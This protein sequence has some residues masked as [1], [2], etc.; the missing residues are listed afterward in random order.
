MDCC[1]HPSAKLTALIDLIYVLEDE[2]GPLVENFLLTY[3]EKK[4]QDLRSKSS[5][6]PPT[7]I[8]VTPSTA[9]PTPEH[10]PI[11]S[12]AA[13]TPSTATPT[14]EHLPVA[15][16]DEMNKRNS[17]R[18]LTDGI[19]GKSAEEV[20]HGGGASL[21]RAAKTSAEAARLLNGAA[22]LQR[23]A[24]KSAEEVP[25]FGGQLKVSGKSAEECI[26]SQLTGEEAVNEKYPMGMNEMVA[27]YKILGLATPAE[28]QSTAQ[29]EERTVTVLKFYSDTEL[30]TVGGLLSPFEV[31]CLLL[32]AE[33]LPE[34]VRYP[35]TDSRVNCKAIRSKLTDM[36]SNRVMGVLPV[37]DGSAL[38]ACVLES[39][40]PG[41]PGLPV[42]WEAKESLFEAVC[43]IFL[44]DSAKG[45]LD[46]MNMRFGIRPE[47]GT[48]V[49]WTKE[50][51]SD[52][53]T[54][55]AVV[56]VMSRLRVLR[57]LFVKED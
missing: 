42:V 57:L 33:T 4:L 16:L 12:L 5:V 24:G 18:N 32:E 25:F 6:M 2:N 45:G 53:R 14:P 47:C 9:T 50:K 35:W 23:A 55:H 11:Q 40:A 43:T 17:K 26:S 7:S 52:K 1:R 20:H 36:I 56:P 44:D 51:V 30:M 21:Q 54:W 41:P 31:E 48:A 34:A 49:F 38:K 15:L 27:R 28:G 39:Y 13:V 3:A 46:F 29:A 10:L 37:P 8:A 22:S 19:S